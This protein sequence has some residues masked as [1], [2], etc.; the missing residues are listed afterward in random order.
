MNLKNPP[1]WKT[2][3]D[4]N[5]D[6]YG[7]CCVD[8]ARKVMEYLDADPAPLQKGYG[9]NT[10]HALICKADDEIKAGG[11]SGYMVAAVATMV[12]TCHARGEEFRVAWNGDEPSDGVVNPAIL[13]IA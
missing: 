7:K 11:I 13:T 1:K 5:Q 9:D 2:Y 12:S 6:P 4:A 8:V 3:E 10:P